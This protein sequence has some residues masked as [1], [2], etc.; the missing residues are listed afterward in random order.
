MARAFDLF[1]EIA[2]VVVAQAG[3]ETERP[4]AHLERGRRRRATRVQAETQHAVHD[5]LEGEAG[6]P[7]F[8]LD[9][10]GNV[11]FEGQ[12]RSHTMMLCARH[13]DVKPYGTHARA[14]GSHVVPAR[15][16]GAAGSHGAAQMPP[17]DA[18]HTVEPGQPGDAAAGSHA[19]VHSPPATPLAASERHSPP[20]QSTTV[21]PQA[22]P[23]RSG[24]S[25]GWHA[26]P[27]HA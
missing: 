21:D 10:I 11:V 13:H 3:T 2:D 9:P 26:P 16:D 23:T 5:R 17:F 27:S 4:R 6:A 15:H 7:R 1:E 19:C 24:A 20:G 22:A 8:G 25:G 14:V 12:R 18:T